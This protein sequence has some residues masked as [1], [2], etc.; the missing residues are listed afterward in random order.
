[1]LRSTAGLEDPPSLPLPWEGTGWPELT[2]TQRPD[3]PG[4]VLPALGE[5]L[6]LSMWDPRGPPPANGTDRMPSIPCVPPDH[7]DSPPAGTL[8]T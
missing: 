5:H 8:L 2:V 6:A 7:P 1:M 4:V 3:L